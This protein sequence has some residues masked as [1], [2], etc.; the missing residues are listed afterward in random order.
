MLR[1]TR[2]GA[3]PMRL[4]AALC[5]AVCLPVLAA[6]ASVPEVAAR[7]SAAAQAAPW[8]QL[9]PLPELL[10]GADAPSRASPAEAE[11]AA[12]AAGLRARAAALRQARG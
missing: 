3:R 7:E 1:A 6:C 9:A 4:P 12:R 5:L 11:L 10:A 8:P 2:T